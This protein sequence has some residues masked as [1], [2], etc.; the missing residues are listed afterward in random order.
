MDLQENTKV[1][2]VVG[3]KQEL[4]EGV[5]KKINHFIPR[6]HHFRKQ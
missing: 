4:D 3:M 6:D 2:L 5:V 1:L